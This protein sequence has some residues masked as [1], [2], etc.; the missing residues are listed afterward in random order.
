MKL[1][2]LFK[3][4][5]QRVQDAVSNVYHLNNLAA[6]IQKHVYLEGKLMDM[7]GAYGFQKGIVNDTSR[8]TN[9]IKIAQIGLTTAT[10]AY[11]LS[12]MATQ[13]KF[14]TIYALPTANDATKLTVTKL[15][16][17]IYGSKTLMRLLDKNID[18]SELKQIN[19]NFLFIRGSKSETAA[20]SISADCLVADEINRC[21]PEVLKQFRSRLQASELKI[22]KQFSTPTISGVGISKE[23]EASRRHRSM[24]KCDCCGHLWLPTYD[25]DIVVPGFN[26]SLLEITKHSIKDIRW[27]DAHWKCPHCGKDPK[28][29][30]DSI[31]W[32]CENPRD[33][34]EANTYYVGPVTCNEVIKPSYMISSYTEYDRK[35][36]WRNQV[37]GEEAEESNDQIIEGDVIAALVHADLTSSEVHYLGA[38]MGLLCNVSIGRL[39]Q[40]GELLVVHREMVSIANFENRRNELIR[41]YRVV[42]SVMDAFPYTS[43]VMRITDF[44]PNAYGCTFTVSKSPELF[45][46]H[47]KTADAEEGKMN[48]RLLKANRTR[49][50]DEILLMFKERKIIV[51][52]LDEPIDRAFIAHCLSMKRTQVFVNEELAY[53]WQKTD[54]ND[55]SMFSLVYLTLACKLRGMVQAT[56]NSVMSLVSSFR[57]KS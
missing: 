44:D 40:S 21:D 54:G 39:T 52:K 23:A 17:L 29:T 38:D 47:L 36:E 41:K 31:E 48:L 34:Y 6:F 42:V 50:L 20:L 57:V 26:G 19:G 24:A 7:S 56:D 30:R 55:H 28:F 3:E 35:A 27:Q 13:K 53:V 9:T 33:N 12:G 46:V 45:T 49:C 43:E 22:I 51:Q 32:V 14:N 2:P 1:N 4:H 8:I 16:P 37:L 10:M 15:N 11:F 5:R 25:L 18:S